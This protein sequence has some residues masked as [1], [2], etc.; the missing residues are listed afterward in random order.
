MPNFV[1]ESILTL[2]LFSALSALAQT[3]AVV[4]T[5]EVTG[6]TAVRFIDRSSASGTSTDSRGPLNWAT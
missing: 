6:E 4:V 1:F 3:A 2:C 5:D